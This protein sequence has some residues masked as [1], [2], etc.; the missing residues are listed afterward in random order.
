MKTRQFLLCL[1]IVLTAVAA[2]PA[3]ISRR[4]SQ[5]TLK[6]LTFT[7]PASLAR[8]LAQVAPQKKGRKALNKYAR[9][10]HALK[11]IRKARN[12]TGRAKKVTKK[13]HRRSHR[14][15][16][17]T[18]AETETEAEIS[19][20]NSTLN[21]TENSSSDSTDSEID[22]D[23]SLTDSV[24]PPIVE[25]T[26]AQSNLFS[27][28]IL[29]GVSNFAYSNADSL[30]RFIGYIPSKMGFDYDNNL[31]YVSTGLGAI[32]FSYGLYD[33]YARKK[34]FKKIVSILNQRY[35]MNGLHGAAIEQENMNLAYINK[36][37][38]Y[39]KAKLERAKRAIENRVH[40][41][42]NPLFK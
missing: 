3:A 31:D 4:F 33:Y 14:H 16:A 24:P 23:E 10:A 36:Q 35:K 2:L 6:G 20:S 13:K 39:S 27:S 42:D 25:P 37:L 30:G 41:F 19:S 28:G 34:D 22:E 11:A 12:R 1:S 38:V 8:F 18:E 17:E 21:E 15:L 26:V 5:E 40:E 9:L 32:G 7:N 29:S